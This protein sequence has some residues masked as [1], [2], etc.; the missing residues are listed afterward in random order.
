MN[1]NGT[2]APKREA[3]SVL[4]LLDWRWRLTVDLRAVS[5]GP[6]V[7]RGQALGLLAYVRNLYFII[8]R[9]A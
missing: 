6:S 3:G 8:G 4:V 7:H 1:R 2:R 5:P 9:Q